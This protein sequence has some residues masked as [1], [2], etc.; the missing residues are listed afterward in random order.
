MYSIST[1]VKTTQKSAGFPKIVRGKNTG[2]LYIIFK[3]FTNY[4][5]YNAVNLTEHELVT[6]GTIDVDMSLYEDYNLPVTLQN[7]VS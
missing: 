4:A 3:P 2:S 7:E 6:V 1:D 5:A